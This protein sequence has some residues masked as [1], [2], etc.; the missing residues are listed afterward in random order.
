MSSSD[1]AAHGE[2]D[3]HTALLVIDT[4]ND[5]ADPEGNL[6]VSGG[7][8]VVKV[9]N[10]EID[11]ARSAG[12]LI[13]YTQ[14]A[15]PESTPHFQKD[16]GVWPVHCVQGTWGWELHPQ[17]A[18]GHG[19]VLQKGTDGGDGYSGFGVADPESGKT[20]ATELDSIL[21][22][23]DI[24]HVVVTGLAADVCVKETVLDARRLDYEAT[25]LAAATRPV[26][27]QPGNGLRA[28]A[29]MADAGA[30]VR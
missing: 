23:R 24:R 20:T 26:D 1:D 4:Q 17:L 30:R 19:P 12:A 6:Y 27:L 5:F 10:S 16:G 9:I 2:Y 13:V 11:A 29:Q 22:E 28:A 18:T 25:L 21:K 8:E 3:A 7:E 14:D 15:H